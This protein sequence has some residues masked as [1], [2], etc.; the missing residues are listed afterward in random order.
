[1][2]IKK[3]AEVSGANR[4]TNLERVANSR[5]VIVDNIPLDLGLTSKELQNFFLQKLREKGLTDV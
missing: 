1:L 3:V 4:E 5:T 2:F